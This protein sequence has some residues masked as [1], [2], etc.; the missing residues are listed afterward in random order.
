MITSKKEAEINAI[1]KI[2]ENYDKIKFQ[3]EN[4]YDSS[5]FDFLREEICLCILYDLNQSAITLTNHFFENFFK[6]MLQLKLGY[7][8]NNAELALMYKDVIDQYDNKNLDDIINVSCSKG[9]ITKDQKKILK[10]LKTKYRNSYS[11]ASKKEIFGDDKLTGFHINPNPKSGENA[12][13][14]V[15]EYET[16]YNLGIQG[17]FQE[18][19]AKNEAIEYFIQLD[20]IIRETLSNFYK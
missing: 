15:K 18:L 10:E 20:L 8:K 19:K 9:L 3:L 16:K 1:K 2:T 5:Q 6:T 17:L 13:S 7:D 4:I 11:H 12:F 14:E